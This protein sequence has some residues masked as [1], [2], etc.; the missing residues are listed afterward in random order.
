MDK[1]PI[2]HFCL[3]DPLATHAEEYRI[4]HNIL[5]PGAAVSS[6]WIEWYHGKISTTNQQYTETRTYGVFDSKRLIGMWSVEPK[7][8]QVEDGKILNTGRCF[9]VGID[10]DYRRMGLFVSLSKYAIEQE[11]KIGEYDYI[12]GYPQKGRSV[13]GGHLK[14]GWELVQGIDIYSY[15]PSHEIG[16]YS[17]A[18]ASIVDDYGLFKTSTTHPG[19]YLES[20]E[21]RNTRWIEHLDNQYLQYKYNDAYII[22][23]PYSNFCHILDF[24][25]NGEDVQILLEICKSLAFRHRWVELNLWCCELEIYKE[26]I[27]KAGFS[28]GANYAFSVSMIAVRINAETEL[29]LEKCHLQMGI[30]EGY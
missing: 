17:K 24:G 26:Q 7:R 27:L 19:S 20:K 9:S 3:I 14:A 21:Y 10:A 1:K 6:D 18:N 13:I 12:L 15:E 2:F 22:I 5:F 11:R 23:K 16:S 29:K 25:G 4:L 8:L 28:G 30:E